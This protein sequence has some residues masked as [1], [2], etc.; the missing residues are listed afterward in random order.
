MW[1]TKLTTNS[2]FYKKG[3]GSV[4]VLVA[5]PGLNLFGAFR[6]ASDNVEHVQR[7]IQ[8]AQVRELIGSDSIRYSASSFGKVDQVNQ[9]VNQYS[10]RALKG[11]W[12]KQAPRVA[13]AIIDNSLRHGFDP[14]LLLAVIEN[15]SRF[16]PEVIGTHGE[17]GLMQLKPDTA[18]W[19]AKKSHIRWNGPESLR[20]PAAN[21]RLGAAYLSML[22]SKFGFDKDLYL[23]AYN[24][25]V[26]NL[27]RL[28]SD[29]GRPQVYPKKT[30]EHYSRIYSEFFDRQQAARVYAGPF[31]AI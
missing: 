29:N 20:D 23:G 11:E 25:G 18:E 9:F 12:K 2:R 22:R 28:L 5:L 31:A 15:E 27:K 30:I 26:T 6:P 21:I 10:A 17:I 1:L 8:L 3:L 7:A 16:N 13:R 19:I 14:L 24:M 4:L